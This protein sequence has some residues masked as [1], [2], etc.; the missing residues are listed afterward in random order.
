MYCLRS[1][2]CLVEKDISRHGGEGGRGKRLKVVS[3]KKCGI[4]GA[5]DGPGFLLASSVSLC[6]MFMS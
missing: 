4:S 6:L 3:G 2:V 5:P 1:T